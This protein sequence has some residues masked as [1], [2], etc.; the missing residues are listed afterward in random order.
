MLT[1]RLT[2]K[3]FPTIEKPRCLTFNSRERKRQDFTMQ[4]LL[5]LST[6]NFAPIL[7]YCKIE[8]KREIV[9]NWFDILILPAQ[10]C[11]CAIR[12]ERR[13]LGERATYLNY[14]CMQQYTHSG[15]KNCNADDTQE[16][17]NTD[18]SNPKYEIMSD[19]DIVLSILNKDDDKDS[20]TD[21]NTARYISPCRRIVKLKLQ[22]ILYYNR[23]NNRKKL[24][25][26]LTVYLLSLVRA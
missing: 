2:R 8:R 9:T 6:Q 20:D 3:M 13:S 14:V 18:K 25:I 22:R 10:D 12:V 23:R 11:L 16:R 1:L 21:E 24:I 4:L 15:F 7:I 17:S 5:Q 19:D 26:F